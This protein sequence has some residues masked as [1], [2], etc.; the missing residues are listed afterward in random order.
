MPAKWARRNMFGHCLQCIGCAPCCTE[1]LHDDVEARKTLLVAPHRAAANATDGGVHETNLSLECRSSE[2]AAASIDSSRVHETDLTEKLECRDIWVGEH[3][4]HLLSLLA[5]PESDS[6]QTG[7]DHTGYV[8]WPVSTLV[9]GLLQSY[10]GGV[11]ATTDVIDLGCGT[12]VAGIAAA[13]C[14]LPQRVVLSDKEPLMRSLARR[15]AR[16]QPKSSAIDVEAYGWS[17]DDSRPAS[18]GSFGLVLASDCLYAAFD[19]MRSY[20]RWGSRYHDGQSLVRFVSMVDWCLAPGG[21][22]LIGFDVRNA[23]DE[24]HM[25][26]ALSGGSFMCEKLSARACLTAAAYALPGNA[27]CHSAIVL[28][29]SRVGE[30][31]MLTPDSKYSESVARA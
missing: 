5:V 2:R 26:N 6:Y 29:C 28:R 25:R 3:R 16:L 21:T 31:V 1:A 17:P 19:E 4:L 24:T 12:G 23:G 30:R 18:R 8:R 14:C 10:A 22:A 11:L 9:T 27:D 7:I 13:V 15:N 20:E